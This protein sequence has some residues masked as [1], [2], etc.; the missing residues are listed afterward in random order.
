MRSVRSDRTLSLCVF[1][2]QCEGFG[3]TNSAPQLHHILLVRIDQRTNMV[4]GPCL[5]AG[6]DD[7]IDIT[8]CTNAVLASLFVNSLLAMLE[9]SLSRL[10]AQAI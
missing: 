3:R 8:V 2:K 7:I 4:N 6:I 10:Q 5:R 1:D 9:P